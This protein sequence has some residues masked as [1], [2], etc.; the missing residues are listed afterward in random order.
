ME[1]ES[2]VRMPP[3]A[4]RHQQAQVQSGARRR[5]NDGIPGNGGNVASVTYRI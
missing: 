4:G 3:V 2:T 5:G 1:G